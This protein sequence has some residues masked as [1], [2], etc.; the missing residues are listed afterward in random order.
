[1]E[2]W[3]RKARREIT[4]A[5]LLTVSKKLNKEA[6]GWSNRQ[7]QVFILKKHLKNFG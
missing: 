3:G 5:V 4:S 6:V 2:K 7:R 1:M